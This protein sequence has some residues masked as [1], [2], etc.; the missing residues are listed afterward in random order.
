MEDGEGGAPAEG[1][2]GEGDGAEPET[3]PESETSDTE[4]RDSLVKL[5][6]ENEALRGENE[7]LR[8]RLAELGGDVELPI[9]EEAEAE[10]E[11]EY[12]DEAAQADLDTQ[13]AQIAALRGAN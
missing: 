3:L 10:A 9:V 1:G 7:A 5:G 4:L 6:A 8:T 11:D 13:A 2:A 12:D